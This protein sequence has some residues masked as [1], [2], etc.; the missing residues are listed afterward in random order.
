MVDLEKETID[1]LTM[2]VQGIGLEWQPA[3]SADL[4]NQNLFLGADEVDSL[5]DGVPGYEATGE[6]LPIDEAEEQLEARLS[7]KLPNMP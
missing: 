6:C 5:G 4:L 7:P 2:P 3:G 1:T